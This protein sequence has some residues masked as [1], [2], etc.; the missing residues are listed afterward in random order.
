MAF[1]ISKYGVDLIDWDQ[2]ETASLFIKASHGSLSVADL[3]A[4]QA[5]YRQLFPNLIFLSLGWIT[6]WNIKAEMFVSFALACLIAINLYRLSQLTL[7]GNNLARLLLMLVTTLLVFSPAQFESWLLGEQIIYFLPATCITTSLCVGYSKLGSN[8]KLIICGLLAIVSTFSS[9]NGLI[10]WLVVAPVLFFSSQSA[11]KTWRFAVWVLSFLLSATVYF[12]GLKKPSYSPS[13]STVLYHPLRGVFFFCAFLGAPLMTSNRLI[14][15]SAG[16]G[17]LVVILFLLSFLYAWKFAGPELRFF[18][19]GWLMLGSYS[20]FTAI[21]VTVG[22]L[23]YGINQSLS[24]R[25]I[26]FS[27]YLLVSLVYLIP[28]I[29]GQVLK[30][31]KL[32]SLRSRSLLGAIAVS[33]L[34]LV[35]VLNSA[36]AVRQMAWM[37]TRRLESKACLLF[38]NVMPHECLSE[39]FPE[40]SVLKSRANALDELHFLKPA[41]IKSNEINGIADTAVAGNISYGRLEALSGSNGTF[42][43]NGWAGLPN[44]KEAA[45]AVLLTYQDEHQ[46]DPIIVAYAPMRV[47]QPSFQGL[48]GYGPTFEWRWR[49]SISIDGAAIIP[50]ISVSAW[51]FDATT[52]RAHKLAGTYVIEGNGGPPTLLDAGNP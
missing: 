23:G 15:I 1:L 13:L 10:C 4:Q 36:A 12:Y 25:Y 28:L 2:W 37:K 38:I 29:G 26:T 19:I 21:M 34:I 24:S 17:A 8:T 43:A 11:W 41:L 44:T 30:R 9:A 42:V 48:F 33:V 27:V 6:H 31:I 22:R 49:T 14:V 5:E 51:A 45:D 16:L 35:H 7:T 50:P 40:L 3:F 47:V 18:L 39:G 32:V 52:G 46:A 20:F